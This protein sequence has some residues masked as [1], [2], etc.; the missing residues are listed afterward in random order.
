MGKGKLKAALPFMMTM[1]ITSLMAG[2]IGAPLVM[3]YEAL[4]LALNY[5]AEKM[6]LESRLP[7]V[8]DL[9][10][11]GDNDFSNRVLSH[12]LISSSTM[13]ID[14]EGFDIGASN[15]WQPIISGIIT[16]EK[17]FLEAMPTI[18]FVLQEAGYMA[19]LG[20]HITGVKTLSEAERRTAA[21]AITPGMYK[22]ITNTL[23][24][25]GSGM[26]PTQK[27]DALVPNTPSEK[28]SKFLGTSTITAS[29][30]RLRER[31]TKEEAMRKQAKVDK[32]YEL[33]A[34]ALGKGDS[35]RVRELAVDLAKNYEQSPRQMQS[36]MESEM[37]KRKMPSGMRQFV[38]KSG[39]MSQKQK[40][41]FRRWQ[42]TY[43]DNPF[44]EEAYE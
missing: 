41:D 12:G 35:E 36:R 4:R 26:V 29:T 44:E 7:S 34:D 28:A 21:L 8:I 27:G 18:N 6:G 40:L 38:G 15:R 1:A 2:V 22:G 42:D 30:E 39:S 19:D 25:D 31:R 23:Y 13:A 9:V 14:E 16:G 33:M 24:D 5:F 11:S 17:T 43:Q 32:K 10:L 3:E 20:M 37:F